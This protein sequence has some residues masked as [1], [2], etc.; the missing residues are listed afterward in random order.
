[1]PR[2]KVLKNCPVC[3]EEMEKY[4]VAKSSKTMHCNKKRRK[5]K[6]YHEFIHR[7]IV[8]NKKSKICRLFL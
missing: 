2:Q 1:M 3:G 8:R 7:F 6:P 5:N 4:Y